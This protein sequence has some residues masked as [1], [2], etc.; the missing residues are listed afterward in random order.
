MRGFEI[1][2]EF[3]PSPKL[4]KLYYTYLLLVIVFGILPW[5]IPLALISPLV[6][7]LILTPILICIVFVALWIHLYYD[8]IV[9]K[10]T[11]SEIV[12]RRGVLFKTTGVVPYGKITNIDIIQGPISKILGIASLKIQTAGYSGRVGAEIRIEGIERFEELRELILKLV[13]GWKP[14]VVEKGREEDINLRILSELIN[15]R[16]LLEKYL[17]QSSSSNP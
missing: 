1:G 12:W 4:I 3:K 9:Y 6:S 5:S 15:I 10:L 16:R 14:T 2:R 11:E 13:K 7:F 8:T 17:E